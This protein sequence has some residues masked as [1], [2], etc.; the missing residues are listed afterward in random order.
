MNPVM[1]EGLQTSVVG[2]LLRG[3]D[4]ARPSLERLERFF[5]HDPHGAEPAAPAKP[6]E[7]DAGV[8]QEVFVAICA[9][10]AETLGPAVRVRRVRYLEQRPARGWAMQGR[11]SIMTSHATRR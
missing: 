5:V 6:H 10:V 4:R 9:A 7:D 3:L 8:P 1:L 2:V 11:V